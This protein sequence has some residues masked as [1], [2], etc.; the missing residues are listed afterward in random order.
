M[1]IRTVPSVLLALAFAMPVA[2]AAD[3][4][5]GETVPIPASAAA[6]ITLEFRGA[7]LGQVLDHLSKEAGFIIANPI[8]LPAPI[9]LLARGPVTPAEAVEALNS[10]LI[11]QNYAAYTR[12]RTLW[13]VPLPTA[14]LQ[15]LPVIVGSDPDK[16]PESDT[17]VTQVMPVQFAGVKEL[18]DNLTPLLNA[19]TTTL[20]INESTN[21]II[22][23]GTQTQIRRVALIIKAIDG[24][25]S[26]EQQVRVFLLQ[27]ASA[28][29]IATLINTIY[30][31]RNGNRGNQQNQPFQQFISGGQGGGRFG[32][33]MQQPGGQQ[34]GSP[35]ARL[36][37]RTV[38][39]TAAADTGTNN[40]V[41]RASPSA[42]LVIE[43]IVKRLDVNT[44][45]RES[46]LV[47]KVKNTKAADLAKNLTDLFQTASTVRGTNNQGGQQNRV[48]PGQG[49]QG[50][51]N[52]GGQGGAEGGDSALDLSGQVRVVADTIGNTVMVLSTERN[53]A[54]MQKLL[55]QLDQPVKQVLVRVLVAEVTVEDGLD[56]GVQLESLS[57]T[58]RSG[59]TSVSGEYSFWDKNAGLSNF[60]LSNGDF[61]LAVRALASNT[62]FDVLS[63]PYVLT[64]DNRQATVNVSQEVPVINGS[65]TD[66]NNN[67]TSTFDRRDVGVI[68]KITP[69]INS[70]GSVVL[71]VNQE[72]SALSDQGIAVA[73][74]IQA[75]I[76]RKRTMTT[77]VMVRNGQ[78]VVIGGL[79]SDTMTERIQ[80]VPLLGDIPI[81]G[82]LFRRQQ[83]STGKTELM[84]FLTP[85]VVAD[86]TSLEEVGQQLRTE[87]ERLNDAV[88]KDELS[89]HLRLM[90]GLAVG[91]RLP[92]PATAPARP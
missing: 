5:N 20:T 37:G 75:P 31:N 71:D 70:E 57:K 41:V 47:Y 65:R 28:D 33:L 1:T 32:A 19:A 17:L 63:R 62:S 4:G 89:K 53:F 61:R 42:M 92:P 91:Q 44:S 43:D 13:I 68:L 15:N 6:T 88:R 40:L 66:S 34:G 90:A 73:K 25:I 21:T 45:A 30:G 72:L 12:G 76:I 46:V 74:D 24:S 67:V 11:A 26:G 56:L 64:A 38:E 81:L 85:Q 50:G 83:K 78:T 14:R 10:V 48:V 58:I 52:P 55:E 51:G 49:G 84:V 16:I 3:G 59:N 29:R 69:Q 7:R 60:L 8:E 54:H 36:S 77:R 82:M 22:L 86:P 2:I 23:T 80:K 79:V 35:E 87:T 9:T 27:H 18:S 39:V